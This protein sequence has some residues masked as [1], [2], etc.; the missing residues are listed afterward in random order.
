MEFQSYCFTTASFN[1][2]I[3]SLTKKIKKFFETIQLPFSIVFSAKKSTLVFHSDAPNQFNA[4]FSFSFP[5]LSIVSPMPFFLLSKQ[6]GHNYN[7]DFRL[8]YAARF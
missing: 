2:K 8:I 4:R 6:F 5:N 3:E 7:N 1:S